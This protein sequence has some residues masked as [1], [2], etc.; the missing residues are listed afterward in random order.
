MDFFS[1]FQC[2]KVLDRF[3]RVIPVGEDSMG[4]RQVKLGR[5]FELFQAC[6]SSQTFNPSSWLVGRRIEDHT[7][8]FSIA[9][10]SASFSSSF[11]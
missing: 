10:N 4:G 8:L 5:K 2:F 11:K 3:E 7:L 1:F 6:K 9:Y